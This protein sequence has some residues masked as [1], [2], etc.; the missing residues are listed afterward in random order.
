MPSPR[1]SDAPPTLRATP[2]GP[3]APPAFPFPPPD[4]AAQLA[5]ASRA[6][7]T[8]TLALMTAFMQ[9]PAPAHRCLLARRIA[10]N[11]ETLAGQDCF[12]AGSRASFAR[13][14]D[15]WLARSRSYAH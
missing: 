4:Q 2:A 11:L 12:D 8:A 13:L 5:A 3:E 15:R 7:W 10:R 1:P 6:L 14:S 9:V